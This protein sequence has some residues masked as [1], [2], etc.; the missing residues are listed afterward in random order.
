M[1]ENMKKGWGSS[2]DI[3][4]DFGPEP[5]PEEV[6]R[7]AAQHLIG[8]YNHSELMRFLKALVDELV[9]LKQEEIKDIKTLKTK[10]ERDWEQAGTRD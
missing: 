1:D 5:V 3:F 9:V 4:A 6:G 10:N 7:H 8:H 2:A